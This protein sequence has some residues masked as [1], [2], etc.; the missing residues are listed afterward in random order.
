MDSQFRVAG[1]HIEVG[2]TFLLHSVA[3]CCISAMGTGLT[4]EST[5]DTEG[6]SVGV[7]IL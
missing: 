4:A 1:K 6:G 2:V 5:E 7:A 3:F